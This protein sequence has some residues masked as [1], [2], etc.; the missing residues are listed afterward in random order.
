MDGRQNKPVSIDALN[1][2]RQRLHAAILMRSVKDAGE[3]ATNLTFLKELDNIYND[4]YR[5]AD[6]QSNEQNSS[7]NCVGSFVMFKKNYIKTGGVVGISEA[8]EKL[9]TTALKEVFKKE[10]AKDPRI[11]DLNIDRDIQVK[12]IIDQDGKENQAVNNIVN[13]QISYSD[14]TVLAFHTLTDQATLAIVENAFT[15]KMFML[16]HAMSNNNLRL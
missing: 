3:F 13:C 11:I 7:V 2:L 12:T 5:L 4:Y 9:F 1:S 15:A 14:N 16:S 8:R 6:Q 10:L